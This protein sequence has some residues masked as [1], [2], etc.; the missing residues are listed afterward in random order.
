MFDNDCFSRKLYS[1][2][3]CHS[4]REI[5]ERERNVWKKGGYDTILGWWFIDLPLHHTLSALVGHFVQGDCEVCN[6]EHQ[7]KKRLLVH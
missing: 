7:L 6:S 2:K 4:N 1:G 3:P 5:N